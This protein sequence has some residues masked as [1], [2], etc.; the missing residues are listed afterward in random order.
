M[1]AIGMYEV[2]DRELRKSDGLCSSEVGYR[3]TKNDWLFV[4]I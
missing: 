2:T 1:L 4:Y 3:K